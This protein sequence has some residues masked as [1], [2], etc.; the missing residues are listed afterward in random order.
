MDSKNGE[1]DSLE[2]TQDPN[3]I[4]T[5]LTLC[6]NATKLT[7]KK[8]LEFSKYKPL[9]PYFFEDLPFP[10]LEA[11]IFEDFYSPI[12]SFAEYVASRVLDRHPDNPRC[13]TSIQIE[14]ERP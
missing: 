4:V 1:W 2:L 11:L 10:P 5:L 8:D 14:A 13:L 6:P 7:F 3:F 12:F 9:D